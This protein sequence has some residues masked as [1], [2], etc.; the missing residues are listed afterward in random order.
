MDAHFPLLSVFPGLTR[1]AEKLILECGGLTP[2]WIWSERQQIKSAVK[3]A[4]SKS[5]NLLTLRPQFL[6]RAR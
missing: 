6:D 1:A 5:S 3:P 4:H 2:L